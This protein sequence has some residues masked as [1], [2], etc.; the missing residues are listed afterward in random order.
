MITWGVKYAV[1]DRAMSLEIRNSA[2]AL[3][4]HMN[5]VM[6]VPYYE[7][8]LPHF[9]MTLV[10]SSDIMRQILERDDVRSLVIANAV[11][12]IF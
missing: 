10:L 7:R 12:D 1:S 4:K 5:L 8:C 9:Q 6:R 2:A 11:P 3:V